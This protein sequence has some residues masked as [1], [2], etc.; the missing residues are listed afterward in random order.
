MSEKPA[1]DVD[2]QDEEIVIEEVE[3]FEAPGRGPANSRCQ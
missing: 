1:I 3:T 2:K